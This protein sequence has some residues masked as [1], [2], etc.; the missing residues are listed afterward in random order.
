MNNARP[1][2][3][4]PNMPRERLMQVL[5]QLTFTAHEA[6]LFLDTHPDCEQA[7]AKFHAANDA[8]SAATEIYV[9]R[10]GPICAFDSAK[11]R[12]DWVDSPWPWQMTGQDKEGEV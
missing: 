3:D 8:L 10:F 7:M 12:W 11:D 5:R 9:D 2:L 6:Q 1:E 4:Y